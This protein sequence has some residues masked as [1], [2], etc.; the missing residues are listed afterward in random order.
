MLASCSGGYDQ[1]DNSVSLWNVGTG[2]QLKK[3]EKRCEHQKKHANG[4]HIIFPV[5]TSFLE[6]DVNTVCMFFP[7][8][9]SC[10]VQLN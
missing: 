7:V 5:F 2:E 8:F 9:T 4:V 10:V 6:N 3:L 1:N